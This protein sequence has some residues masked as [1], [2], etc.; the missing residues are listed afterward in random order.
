M[1]GVEWIMVKAY[2]R[3][4]YHC[5]V[6]YRESRR[7]IGEVADYRPAEPPAVKAS[8]FVP[9]NKYRWF[10]DVDTA[11]SWVIGEYVAGVMSGE[12]ER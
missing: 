2:G 8:I 12:I 1:N 9:D 4:V 11:K 5:T 3:P 6:P 7:Y 10:V